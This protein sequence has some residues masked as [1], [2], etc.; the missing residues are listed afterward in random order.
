MTSK[1]I[2]GQTAKPHFPRGRNLDIGPLLEKIP[3]E[4]IVKVVETF[5]EVIKANKYME[6]QD[7]NFRNKLT[8]MQDESTSTK[9]K[10]KFLI[11]L[12]S[13]EKIQENHVTKI[14]DTICDIA[15]GRNV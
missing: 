10:M 3:A 12:I 6:I 1:S 15:I 5:N 7:Q 8:L 14:V 9:D 2:V 4:S 13:Q 11:E